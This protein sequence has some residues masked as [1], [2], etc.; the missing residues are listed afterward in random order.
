MGCILDGWTALAPSFEVEIE[1]MELAYALRVTRR[2]FPGEMPY[3]RAPRQS[4]ATSAFKDA[5]K[6][7]ICASECVWA[8]SDWDPSRSL[9]LPALAPLA[10]VSGVSFL[11]LQ[12]GPAAEALPHSPLPLLPLSRWT[13]QFATP[14]P[15]CGSSI[16]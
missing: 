6:G 7:K 4:A 12:Q 15:P 16:W 10:S 9:D 2:R 1:V 14:A 3:L 8:A 5:S 11:S 13:G